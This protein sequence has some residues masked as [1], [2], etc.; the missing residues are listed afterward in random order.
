MIT[1]LIIE[2]EPVARDILRTYIE[3]TPSLKLIDECEDAM[4]A[5]ELLKK[6]N[7]D[8][9]FL[10]I[11]MP[12]LSGISF[13]KSLT[14]PPQVILT[15]AYSEYALEGYELNVLD[16]LLKPFSFERFLK[17]VNKLNT[18][19]SPNP[20]TDTISIKAD[21]KVY[22]I[23]L[24]GIIFAESK[25]DY[26]TLHTESKKLTFNQTLTS[27]IDSLKDDSFVRVH[28]SYMVNLKKIDYLEGNLI[29][30]Q[31]N[32]I[33]IGKSYKEEFRRRFEA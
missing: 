18:L 28:R 1:C 26:I 21:G 30:I 31:K 15:T 11:N 32:E 9:I 20:N 5:L 17:A 19:D 25:G 27:F 23:D 10:D 16:Y 33:P 14:D 8:L 22:P 24:R 29:V 7:I 6:E 4:S 2:D 3:D 13:L 12:K